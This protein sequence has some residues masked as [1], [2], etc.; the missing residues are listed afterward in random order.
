MALNSNSKLMGY[1]PKDQEHLH[2]KERPFH[3]FPNH[4]TFSFPILVIRGVR[5][6]LNGVHHPKIRRFDL[7]MLML[8]GIVSRGLG[9]LRRR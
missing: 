1:R 9:R 3:H 4:S 6:R 5:V 8:V 7:R 2:Y